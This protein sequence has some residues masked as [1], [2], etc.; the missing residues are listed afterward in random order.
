VPDSNRKEFTFHIWFAR[1]IRSKNPSFR[2]KKLFK[3][4]E[5]IP[6]LVAAEAAHVYDENTNNDDVV[7]IADR[8]S[9]Y[10]IEDD[11]T[12][13]AAKLMFDVAKEDPTFN[14]MLID[15]TVYPTRNK[16]DPLHTVVLGQVSDILRAFE[17]M[18]RVYV[19]ALPGIKEDVGKESNIFYTWVL[20]H[21]VIGATNFLEELQRERDITSTEV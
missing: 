2:Y 17:N 11:Y 20:G 5:L 13:T 1:A 19:S 8:L 12:I 7:Q 16:D 14:D 6:L 21:A 15:T 9:G 3:N 4:M 10:D 18:H